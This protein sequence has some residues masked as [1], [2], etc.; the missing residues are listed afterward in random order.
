MK[1]VPGTGDEKEDSG[2]TREEVQEQERLRSDIVSEM[3]EMIIIR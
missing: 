1:S 2:L 3:I